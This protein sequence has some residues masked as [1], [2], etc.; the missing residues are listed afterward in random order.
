MSA[1]SRTRKGWENEHLAAYLL[2]RIAFM[3]SPLNV[4]DDVGVDFMCTL[5]E[6][7][8]G[9]LFPKLS[10]A[11]QVKSSDTPFRFSSVE[12][13][14]KLTMP[15]FVGVLNRNPA[16]LELYSGD[17]IPMFFSKVGLASVKR[18]E[19][20]PVRELPPEG[21]MD[22]REKRNHGSFSLYMPRVATL[23]IDDPASKCQA[24]SRLLVEECMRTQFNLSSRRV[25]QHIYLT[26]KPDIVLI[27]AGS[28]SALTF[29]RNF[30]WRLAEVFKNLVWIGE[31]HLQDLPVR[32]CEIFSSFYVELRA[33]SKSNPIV[34]AAY[35]ELQELIARVPCGPMDHPE[36]ERIDTMPTG[37]E[38]IQTERHP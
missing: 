1:L 30:Y 3:S 15:F 32:E 28:G 23:S 33:H 31:N 12:Y 8:A 18:L 37:A 10:F 26:Q 24:L 22:W 29:R 19:I 21:E 20:A 27:M 38:H 34:E 5:F 17:S 9:S 25:G 11:I 7:T 35:A 14:E 2:S 6:K 13:L 16:D 36:E 4:S